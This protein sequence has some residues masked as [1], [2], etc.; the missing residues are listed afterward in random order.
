MLGDGAVAVHPSDARY[1]PIVGKMCEIPVGPQAQRRLIPIITYEYPDPDFGSGAVKITGAHDFNDYQVA[2]RGNIPMY[3]LMDTKGAMRADGRPYI[4][5]AS[6]A[7]AIASGKKPFDEASIAAM[8]LVPEAYRGLDRF[9]ARQ[10]IIEDI[11]GA[12]LA[13]MTMLESKNADTG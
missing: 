6:D 1:A 4:E 3:S 10:R 2:K 11:T 8:N 12:G 7:K 13:V 5:E 9:E